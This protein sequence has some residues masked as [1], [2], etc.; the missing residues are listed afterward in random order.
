MSDA[1]DRTIPATPRRREAARLSG[2]MPSAALPGWIA[3]VGVAVVLLP[4][5]ARSTVPEAID[6]MRRSVVAAVAADAPTGPAAAGFAGEF[7]PPASLLLPTVALIV[8]AGG[9][10]LI[11][12]FL[13]DGSA[14]RL[15]R[16]APTFA[17]IDPLAGFARIASSA[18][19]RVM[20]DAVV[21]LAVLAAAAA[22]A[23]GPLFAVVSGGDVHEPAGALAV[24]QR[25]LVPLVATAAVLA[26]C[27][28]AI[29]RH[30]F[31][32]RLRMTP[33]EYADESRS[34]QADPKIRLLHRRR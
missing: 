23:V 24:A 20:L 3:T 19:A 6:F 14:W 4:A 17:R 22:F 28:W 29:A 25:S 16:A 5:W 12:R 8:V 31:E 27:Q 33:Q 9:V 13:L 11:V 2:A 34:L 32:R 30:R 21:G 7:V 1:A 10:G 18:T 26:F 15:G